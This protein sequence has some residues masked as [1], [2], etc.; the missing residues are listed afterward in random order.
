MPIQYNLK[1]L[2]YEQDHKYLK[3]RNPISFVNFIAPKNMLA[4]I[5]FYSGAKK[6][7]FLKFK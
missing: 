6:V 5:D 4:N 7:L 3:N 2:I 1:Y